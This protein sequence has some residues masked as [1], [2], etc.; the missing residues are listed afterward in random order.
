MAR[1]TFRKGEINILCTDL[2]TSLG[3]W[4][5]IIGATE[6]GEE[7]GAMRLQLGDD[8]L[9]LLP[10]AKAPA[11]SEDY[12]AHARISFDLLTDDLAATVAWLEE[13]GVELVETFDPSAGYAIIRDPD[14]LLVEIVQG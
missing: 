1:P 14:G 2:S 6:L 5:D 7:D 12:Y 11:E 9:L 4:R 8:R 3:F 13:Q 10:Y